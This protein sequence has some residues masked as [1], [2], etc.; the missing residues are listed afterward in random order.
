[1]QLLRRKE[2]LV[3]IDAVGMNYCIYVTMEA[4]YVCLQTADSVVTIMN[5]GA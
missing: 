3:S 4:L 2:A 5:R 1:M